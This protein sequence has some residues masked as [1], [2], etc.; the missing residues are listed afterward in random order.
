M[1]GG[2]TGD[3]GQDTGGPSLRVTG[4][5]AR[6]E[7]AEG[8]QPCPG[9]HVCSSACPLPRPSCPV[10]PAG[11]S[12]RSFLPGPSCPVLPARSFLPVLPAPFF[13]PGPRRAITISSFPHPQHPC[14]IPSSFTRETKFAG[15]SQHHDQT[16]WGLRLSRAAPPDPTWLCGTDTGSQGTGLA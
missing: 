12:C 6:K 3:L 5:E 15:W 9:P 14:R 4:Q 2:G 13:L 7:V 11:P 1:A 10:L 16:S 8:G